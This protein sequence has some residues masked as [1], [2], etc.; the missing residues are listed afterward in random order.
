MVVTGY[1]TLEDRDNIDEIETEGPFECTRPN[2][3]LGIGYYFWDSKIEWAISWGENAYNKK[4][5]DFVIGSCIIDLDKDCFDLF[6]NVGCQQELVKIISEFK[7]SGLI[8]E[9]QDLILPNIIE[10][11][12]QQGIFPYKSIRSYD[13]YN[14][15]KIYF[16]GNRGEYT[17]VNQRVQ[18]CVIQKENVILTSFKVIYPKRTE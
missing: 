9:N 2:A 1:Q 3:W 15:V 4:G 12:K 16:P 10:Y 18:I 6:G 13:N 7:E 11:L 17:E 8:D 5:M 14:P